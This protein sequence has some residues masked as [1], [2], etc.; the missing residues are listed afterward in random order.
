MPLTEKQIKDIAIEFK[1][2]TLGS[3]DSSDMCYTISKP[4]SIHLKNICVENSIKYGQVQIVDDFGKN[5]DVDHFWIEVQTSFQ[6]DATANQFNR[7]LNQNFDYVHFGKIT[8]EIILSNEKELACN[9]I[10]PFIIPSFE[11]YIKLYFKAAIILLNDSKHVD[12][13][14]KYLGDIC[15]ALENLKNSKK[16]DFDKLSTLVDTGKFLQLCKV[17]NI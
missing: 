7:K 4:L 12:D 16:Q 1:R 5:K 6:I 15:K 8:K 13:T 3:D 17:R 9:T 10:V 14:T 11:K 2:N